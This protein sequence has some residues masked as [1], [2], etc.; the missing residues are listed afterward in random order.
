[1]SSKPMSIRASLAWSFVAT[2][3]WCLVSLAF[4]STDFDPLILQA[5]TL[6]V[7]MFL[8]MRL[9]AVV[10]YW[11]N[12]KWP[13]NAKTKQSEKAQPLETKIVSDSNRSEHARRRRE[14]SRT[15]SKKRRH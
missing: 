1:M 4:I 5:P 9:G 10:S 13:Q 8:S 12:K 3:I 15:K 6:F 2:F 11:I 14:S 7:M